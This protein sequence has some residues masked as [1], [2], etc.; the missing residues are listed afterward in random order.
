MIRAQHGTDPAELL[1]SIRTKDA[2]TAAFEL[3]L[4]QLI[5]AKVSLRLDEETITASFLGALISSFAWTSLLC[6][7]MDALNGGAERQVG[8]TAYKKSGSSRVS[9]SHSGADFGLIIKHSKDDVRIA[10]FQAKRGL[11]RRDLAKSVDVR[12]KV[13]MKKLKGSDVTVPIIQMER[14]ALS[15]LDATRDDARNHLPALAEAS[16]EGSPL[17]NFDRLDWIHYLGF[18]G[19]EFKTIA[20]NQMQN[21]YHDEVV[22]RTKGTRNWVN[23]DDQNSHAFGCIIRAGL[24]GKPDAC[25]G[26]A[27]MTQEAA[28]ALAFHLIP[29]IDLFVA[30]DGSGSLF[31][32]QA[33]PVPGTTNQLTNAPVAQANA[34]QAALKTQ[35]QETLTGKAPRST[36]R[37][38]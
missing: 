4:Q 21:A 32:P 29:M 15:G 9:E 25:H 27:S 38:G 16:V 11:I 30:D 20:L 24:E 6:L 17:A 18:Y 10:I 8:W 33:A 3:A 31:S 28:E 14:L 7:P 23:M 13:K 5:D 36:F 35:V 26:W 1:K 19:Q 2:V 22:D 34:D 12:R 37:M